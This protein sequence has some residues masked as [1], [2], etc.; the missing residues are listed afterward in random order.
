MLML[1]NV[2]FELSEYVTFLNFNYKHV[3]AV[4]LTLDNCIS[5]YIIIAAEK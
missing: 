1:N 3:R 4:E 2:H 5:V